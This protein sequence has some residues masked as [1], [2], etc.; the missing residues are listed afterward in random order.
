MIKVF[1]FITLFSSGAF[2]GAEFFADLDNVTTQNP[3][4]KTLKAHGLTLESLRFS[5]SFFWSPELSLST[6]KTTYNSNQ[7]S[8]SEGDY[9]KATATWNL[10][11]GG[12]EYRKSKAADAAYSSYL[13]EIQDERKQV[14]LAGALL[15]FKKIF[16]IEKFEVL[17][18]LVALKQESLKV[19]QQRFQHG[20][21]PRQEVTK[22]E[23]DLAQ[24]ESR[25][26]EA[27]IELIDNS[28]QIK[29]IIGAD[30]VT[31]TWPFNIQ[32]KMKSNTNLAQLALLQKLEWSKTSRQ[33]LYKAA[34][35]AFWP[36]LDLQ[37][38]Y[39]EA[40]LHSNP[41]KSTTA[42]L[43][44]T[45]PL[46]SRWDSKATQAQAYEDLR[47]IENQLAQ[48]QREIKNRRD[49]ALEKLELTRKNLIDSE[50]NLEKSKRL[51][52]DILK[53]FRLGRIT[54][55]DLFQEQTRLLEV[56]QNNLSQKLSFHSSFVESCYLLSEAL[57]SCF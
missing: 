5:K 25:R 35:G 32:Q 8:R 48:T 50:S 36:S 40:P 57:K 2:A 51:Y 53:N 43:V 11:Q 31:K 14:E 10:F 4:L 7:Q 41:E 38:D 22:S 37:V 33:E 12:S 34:D 17:S 16:L 19:V 44:L 30:F 54:V 26:R 20:Q 46:W 15:I 3:D 23:V 52:E 9:W 1:I 39:K 55:N 28:T 21:I 29:N 56:E 45:I 18:R 27:Q 42:A 24:A 49:V 13:F 6:G 47:R